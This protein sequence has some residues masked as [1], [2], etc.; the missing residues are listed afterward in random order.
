MR[1]LVL[2][3]TA[4]LGRAVVAHAL[5]EGHDVTCLARGVSGDVPPGAT[6]VRRDRD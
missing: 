1:L 5:A 3:G 4:M 2:G 6:W